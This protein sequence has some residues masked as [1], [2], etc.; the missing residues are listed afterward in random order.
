MEYYSE[1]EGNKL[2]THDNL[3]KF[4][5]NYAQWGGGG[6]GGPYP[7]ML[8]TVWLHLCNILEIKKFTEMETKLIDCQGS[9]S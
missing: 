3:D 2:S 5:G 8:H 9:R 4:Q 6:G 7:T 1:I